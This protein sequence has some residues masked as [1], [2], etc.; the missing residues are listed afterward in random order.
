MGHRSCLHLSDPLFLN[1]TNLSGK[2]K[3]D[4]DRYHS[5][6][7]FY[8]AYFANT[9]IRPIDDLSCRC[10]FLNIFWSFRCS[11]MNIHLKDLKTFNLNTYSK[12]K[13]MLFLFIFITFEKKNNKHVHYNKWLKYYYCYYSIIWFFMFNVEKINVCILLWW[14]IFWNFRI[15]SYFAS[16]NFDHKLLQATL[17]S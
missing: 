17:S 16:N 14:Y 11:H 5:S 6:M 7:C 12:Q 2:I 13:K 3:H 9:Y 15:F 1:I 10:Q 8:F 4:Q